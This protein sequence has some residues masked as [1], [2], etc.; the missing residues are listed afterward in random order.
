LVS[1]TIYLDNAPGVS[2][3]SYEEDTGIAHIRGA[4]LES[5]LYA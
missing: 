2:S 3:I 1:G 5:T 4:N